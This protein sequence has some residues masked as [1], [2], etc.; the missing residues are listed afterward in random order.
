MID[1]WDQIAPQYDAWYAT[2][3]G[4]FAREVEIAALDALGGQLTGRRGL[5]V[6]CGTGQFGKAFAQGG[7]RMVGVDR[8][9][10]MLKE[11]ARH[12]SETLT[13]CRADGERLPFPR[14]SFD[15]VAA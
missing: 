14:S 5:E 12:V 3:L 1:P 2:P 6:G 13:L 15:L 8:S 10:A 11:A 9:A 7:V 4:A